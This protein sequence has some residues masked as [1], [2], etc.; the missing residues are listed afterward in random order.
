MP[1]ASYN[2]IIVNNNGLGC[3]RF[4][5]R[6]SGNRK[7]LLPDHNGARRITL[8]A[9]LQRKNKNQERRIEFK[10]KKGLR[11]KLLS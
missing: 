1:T 3:S 8:R 7:D 2:P 4:A 6:Y 10:M 11:S 5:R 9:I